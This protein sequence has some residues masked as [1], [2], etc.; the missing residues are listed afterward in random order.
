[1]VLDR[2]CDEALDEQNRKMNHVIRIL[3]TVDKDLGTKKCCLRSIF[4]GAFSL[5]K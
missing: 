3:G 2:L 5:F 4:N 1:M